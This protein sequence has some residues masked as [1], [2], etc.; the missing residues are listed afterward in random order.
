[1]PWLVSAPPIYLQWHRRSSILH[2][3]STP[4]SY[5]MCSL[6]LSCTPPM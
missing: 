2:P 3:F 5:A 4:I 6:I 1:L